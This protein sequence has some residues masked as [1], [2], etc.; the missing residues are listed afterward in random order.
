[1]MGLPSAI[2]MGFF[3]NQDWV[4]SLG[5]M[6]SGSF[7]LILVL[8]IGPS[9]FRK[10][11]MPDIKGWLKPGKGFDFLVK[12]LLPVQVVAMIVWWFWDSYKNNPENWLNPFGQSTVGT[13]LL[14]WMVAII[15]FLAINK[16][17]VKSMKKAGSLE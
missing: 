4:W 5:L 10:E 2:F 16:I 12:F 6:V 11:I 17:L 14:Q 15:V 13:V 9:K 7:L 1:V 3:D 8:K